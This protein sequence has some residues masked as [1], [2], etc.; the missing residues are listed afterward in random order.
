[1]NTI[2]NPTDL[3]KL[4]SE[5]TP[6][7]IFDCRSS[8]MD[9]EAGQRAFNVAHIP[10]AQFAHLTKDLSGPIEPGVTGRHPLPTK[11]KFLA[12]LCEWGVTN[13][14]TVV[15]Y[16]DANGAFAARLW[17]MMR[18]VGHSQVNVLNGGF[19]NWLATELPTNAEP[20]Q[21]K[22]SAFKLGPSISKTMEA[23]VLLES[24]QFI[25]DAR[26]QERFDG[27]VEPIDPIAGHIP[28]A[29]CLP[30]SQNLTASIQFKSVEEL[31]ARFVQAGLAKHSEAICYCG[32]GVTAAH[33]ILALVHAGFPEPALYPGSWSEWITDAS[34]PIAT[35]ISED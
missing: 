11:E 3:V 19:S 35:N 10:G 15:A 16:D 31:N 34:R 4:K 9:E 25:I 1:M 5:G 23:D 18:W 7:C 8:L 27:K 14:S 30:F 24:E 29:H 13:E 20:V 33:N 28:G 26:D 32:S 17:W 21:P 12:T 22:H 2:I 6:L